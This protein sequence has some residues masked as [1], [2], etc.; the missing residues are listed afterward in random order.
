MLNLVDHT[1]ISV[2]HDMAVSKKKRDMLLDLGHK[3]TVVDYKTRT[4][5]IYFRIKKLLSSLIKI[6]FFN[7]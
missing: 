7:S 5:S 3:F 6:S 2:Q 1:R 4:L